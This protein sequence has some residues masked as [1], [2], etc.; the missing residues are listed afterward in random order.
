M[1]DLDNLIDR[2]LK[3]DFPVLYDIMIYKIDGVQNKEIIEKIKEKHNSSYSVEYLSTIWRKKI[4]KIIA[5]KAKEDWIIWHY[6]FEEKGKWKKCS[7]CHRI[8]IAHP[9]F[10]SKNKTSKDGWYS[11]C[12]EC[13]NKK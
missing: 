8:K 2:A 11:M 4:P 3:K 12:K 9:Y 1:E 7:R 5:E 6:T 10:F 13:R